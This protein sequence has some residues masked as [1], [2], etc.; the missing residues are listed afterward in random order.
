MW[1]AASRANLVGQTGVNAGQV[2]ANAIAEYRQRW[3]DY[4]TK[5]ADQVAGAPEKLDAPPLEDTFV[6]AM[7][8]LTCM[9]PSLTPAQREAFDADVNQAATKLQC[10]IP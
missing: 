6:N 3:R 8:T 7:D 5:F 1:T 10:P 9:R 2:S 4:D